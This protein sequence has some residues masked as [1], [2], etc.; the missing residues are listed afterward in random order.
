MPLTGSSIWDFFRAVARQIVSAEETPV[1]R[2]ILPDPPAVAQTLSDEVLEKIFFYLA[3]DRPTLASCTLVCL[4]WHHTSSSKFFRLARIEFGQK[5]KDRRLQQLSAS[6]KAKVPSRLTAHLR[7]LLISGPCMLD[8]LALQD[9]V[10]H[11]PHLRRLWV[12]A[13]QFVPLSKS[14]WD[15]YIP[16]PRR[17]L[18]TLIVDIG[19]PWEEL[20]PRSPRQFDVLLWFSDLQVFNISQLEET[21]CI[22]LIERFPERRTLIHT[23]S[24]TFS[25][26][27]SLA[28]L[29]DIA[30]DPRSFTALN[31]N[32]IAERE[33]PILNNF[34]DVYGPNIEQCS[35][36]TSIERNGDGFLPGSKCPISN[37]ITYR[38]FLKDIVTNASTRLIGPRLG[39]TTP[40]RI[41][42]SACP[43]LRSLHLDFT[44]MRLNPGPSPSPTDAPLFQWYISSL[45][46]AH[47]LQE[48][49]ISL[50]FG[51]H[52]QDQTQPITLPPP[53]LTAGGAGAFP[54]PPRPQTPPPTTPALTHFVRSL[55][56]SKFDAH[57]QQLL[58][59]P[60]TPLRSVVFDVGTVLSDAM[61][62]PPGEIP[63]P[64]DPAAIA[65]IH[66]TIRAALSPEVRQLV[67]D[68]V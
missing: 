5:N 24:L 43:N 30:V 11:L 48:L 29:N 53:A 8:F 20:P 61:I 50:H 14:R 57:V 28:P 68:A 21:H 51:V 62:F 2:R 49:Q 64:L 6:S 32:G 13:T 38:I 18:D 12:S 9:A 56:W 60:G 1:Q 36:E 26:L 66:N 42:L 40:D 3:F 59:H 35:I 27:S 39:P 25:K 47:S 10:I 4:R 44:F 31:V 45:F 63:P 15:A 19:Y 67:K 17:S 54:P 7:D 41:R 52:K 34:L 23:L 22:S 55:G 16:P 33:M 65:S 58:A 46:H 37:D